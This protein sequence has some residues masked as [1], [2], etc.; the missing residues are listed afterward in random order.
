MYLQKLISYITLVSLLSVMTGCFAQRGY[1]KAP[2]EHGLEK[3]MRTVTYRVSGATLG[4][5]MK[6]VRRKLAVDS[7]FD[8]VH[9]S[10]SLEKE[11]TFIEFRVENV[12]P[13]VPSAIFFWISI[14][15]LTILPAWSTEDGYDVHITVYENGVKKR[16]FYYE[17]R[18]STFIWLF[19]LPLLPVNLIIPGE[20]KAFTSIINQFFIDFQKADL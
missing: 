12:D 8:N 18:R 4:N 3:S 20:H 9:F 15:T 14:F 11:G 16:S 2:K 5:G 7:P 13:S 1:P 6:V 10:T 19:A 17:S